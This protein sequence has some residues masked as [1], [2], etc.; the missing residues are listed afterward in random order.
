VSRHA[1]TVTRLKRRRNVTKFTLFCFQKNS[2]T[3]QTLAESLAAF[4]PRD[5][6]HIFMKILGHRGSAKLG[7]GEPT[8]KI[9]EY[10]ELVY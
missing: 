3:A 1:P 6:L 9:V 2:S 5:M 8:L 4:H 10:D 7:L